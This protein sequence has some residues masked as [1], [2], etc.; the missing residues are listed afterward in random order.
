V[1][2]TDVALGI[3]G[4]YQPLFLSDFVSIYF[5]TESS[6]IYLSYIPN[7]RRGCEGRDEENGKK[8][9]LASNC[10]LMLLFIKLRKGWFKVYFL[11]LN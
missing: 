3:F 8:K 1:F 7:E 11:I 9:T 5:Q 6:E 2:I 4:I 10:E